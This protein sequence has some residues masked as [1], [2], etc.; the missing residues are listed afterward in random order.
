[1]A[2]S[3]WGAGALV[4]SMANAE[5]VHPGRGL[6]ERID[7]ARSL[8][9]IR[10]DAISNYMAAMTMPFRV[11]NAADLNGV[12]AGDEITFQLH[13]TDEAS[14]ITD[15]VKTGRHVEPTVPAGAGATARPAVVAEN[16]LRTYAFT[17]ELGRPVRLDDFRGQAQAI[18]FFYTRCPLPEYCPRLSKNFAMAQE[19][20]EAMAGAPTNWH[21]LSISFD[22][23]FDSPTTL[24]N[25]G[26]SYRYDPRH[27]S[28][29]T[30]PPEK[31]AALAKAAGVEFEPDGA[32]INHNFRTLI[33]DASGRLQMVF[34]TTGDLSDEI[35]AEILKAAAATNPSPP[36]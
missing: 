6:V 1:M 28:F 8:V 11:T 20:L 2:L 7:A 14:W 27:W 32:T 21:F 35:V 30:G 31:I 17:N 36:K 10:H 4:L 22:T 9:T 19:K 29:L 25:Y 33:V 16:S 18:T 23:G 15:V 34:P 24:K 26:E 5:E 3:I 13:V 12:K